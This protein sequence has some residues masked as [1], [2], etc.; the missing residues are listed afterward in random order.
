MTWPNL[1]SSSPSTRHRRPAPD[2]PDRLRPRAWRWRYGNVS[3]VLRKIALWQ[4]MQEADAANADRRSHDPWRIDAGAIGKVT[5]L[6]RMPPFHDRA[7]QAGGYSANTGSPNILQV[8]EWSRFRTAKGGPAFAENALTERRARRF[9]PDEEA[10][11]TSGLG[12][13]AGEVPPFL[14]LAGGASGNPPV[15]RSRPRRPAGIGARGTKRIA[16]EPGRAA[17]GTARAETPGEADAS[18]GCPDEPARA[19]RRQGE[20]APAPAS[21]PDRPAA[22]ATR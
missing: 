16:P 4:M 6:H 17:A 19:A 12:R 1:P 20:A 13:R 3:A 11:W 10:G 21:F 14:D 9:R 22:G 7:S 8:M 5:V 18:P 15:S 2:A